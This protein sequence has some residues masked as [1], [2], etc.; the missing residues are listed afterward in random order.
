MGASLRTNAIERK[1]F[2]W[3]SFAVLHSAIVHLNF[4]VHVRDPT[5]NIKCTNIMK[6]VIHVPLEENILQ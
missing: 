1:I 4:K 3:S 2:F 6:N 5:T